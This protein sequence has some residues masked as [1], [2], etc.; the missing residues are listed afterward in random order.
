MPQYYFHLFND[1]TVLDKEGAHL[2]NQAVAL[3]QAAKMAR[4]MAAVSVREGKL[5]L[6]HRIEVTDDA[7]HDVGTVHFRDVVDIRS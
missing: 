3:Q 5:V 6:A 7:N 2:P 1:E 4:E